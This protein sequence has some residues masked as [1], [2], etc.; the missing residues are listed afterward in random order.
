MI[1]F[2]A[3]AQDAPTRAIDQVAG[4]VYRFQ[5][6]FHYALVVTTDEGVVVVDPINADAA[7]WLKNELTS[8]TD[9]PVTHLIYSHSHGDHA[10]GGSVLAEG[11]SVIAHANAPEAIDGVVPTI[12]FDDTYTFESGDHTFELTYLGPGHGTDLIAV[13]VRPENVAFITDAAAPKRLPF[14]DMGGANLDDWIEQIKVVESLDFEVFA[15]AHGN[16]GVKADA[17]DAR[18]YMENLREQVLSGLRA[19]KSVD[20]LTTEI[21]LDEYQDWMQFEEFRPL[22]IQGMARFLTE[23][24]QVN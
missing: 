7:A 5:N 18:I 3:F 16:I 9:K 24:G 14:R 11:A 13:V 2:S 6:N 17:A 1:T 10:S 15:P 19:G 8:I 21:T 23:S 22:N 4:N 20:E 12:R